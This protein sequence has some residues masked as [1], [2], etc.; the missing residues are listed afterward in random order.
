[1]I[2]SFAAASMTAAALLLPVGAAVVV[3]A[4]VAVAAPAAPSPAELQGKLQAAL[5]GSAAELESGDTS[6]IRN[7]GQVISQIPG[8]NWDVSGPVT[9]DGDVLSATLNSRLG[10]YSYPIPVTWKNVGGTWKL[11]RESEELL[12][13]YANMAY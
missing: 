5:N 10:E 1:M 9:V 12:A 4:P 13:S 11:S 8:Y 3:T 6:K 2:R 7:V